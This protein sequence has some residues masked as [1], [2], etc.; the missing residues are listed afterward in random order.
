MAVVARYGSSKA[1][2]TYN[3]VF[4]WADLI[5][6]DNISSL[7]PDSRENDADAWSPIGAWMSQIK[8]SGRA[9]ISVLRQQ[10]RYISRL[11]QTA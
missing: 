5:I 1:Q 11:K 10:V 2:E 3:E 6:L 4:D 7:W 9:V 8:A